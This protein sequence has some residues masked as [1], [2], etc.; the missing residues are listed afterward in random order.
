MI[1]GLEEAIG[2]T[3]PNIEAPEARPFLENLCKEHDVACSNP[4][5]VARLLDKLVGHFLEDTYVSICCS[6]MWL[7]IPD[8]VA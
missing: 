3:F 8:V 7:F 1:S 2:V 5:T 6:C 4:R